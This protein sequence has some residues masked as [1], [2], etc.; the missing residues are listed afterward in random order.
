MKTVGL[1]TEY[2]PFHNGHLY[3]IEKAKEL[4]GADR[5]I[6]VLSGNYV[7]R[8]VPAMMPKELRTEAALRCG[9]SLVIELPVCYSTGTAEQFAYGAVSI[10]NK[11]GGVDF[12]CFGSESGNLK[13]MNELAQ[14]LVEEPVEFQTRL[15]EFV[16]KGYSFPLSRQKAVCDLYPDSHFSELLEQ[17]NNILGIEYLKA[18]LRL[19]S[20][21]KPFTIKRFASDYHENRLNDKY[22]SASAIRH[23]VKS[24]VLD[25]IYNQVPETVFDLYKN[26]IQ[27]RYPVWV[28]DFSLLLKYRL[29]SEDRQSLTQYADIS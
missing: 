7:Q 20:K 24:E 12:L 3:H 21:I 14:I 11:L 6:V 29:L 5:I 17:P 23:V 16:R 26:T 13:Q 22:S 9:A 2:N 10:L 27:K 8:G 4:T 19:N 25:D 15:Q 18:L 1:I 28:N